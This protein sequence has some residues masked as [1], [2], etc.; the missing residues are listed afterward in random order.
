[1]RIAQIA[2]L[3][4]SVPPKTYGGAELVI[5]LLTEELV[6]RG[7]DVTL[8]AP[9]DS[10]TRARLH[11][12]QPVSVAEAMATRAA[13]EYGHYANA[14]MADALAVSG[15]FDL[16]HS[17]L[18]CAYAP[19]AV[20][21]AAPVLHTP[22]IALSLDDQWVLHHYPDTEI[23]AISQFQ[24]A[25]VPDCARGHCRVIHHGIDFSSY[26][27][28]ER[29][30]DYLLFLGRMG[31]QK[32]PLDAVRIAQ[33]AGLPLVLAGNPENDT[34]RAYFTREVLP[35]VDGERVT[36]VGAV[37]PAAK[38]ILLRGAVALLFPIRADEA[39]GLAMVEAMASGTPVLA[40][41]HSSTPEIVEEG[42]TG[43][44]GSTNEE[45]AARV[46][47]AMR[48]DRQRIRRQ[49]EQR[50]SHVRMTDDYLRVYAE[51]VEAAAT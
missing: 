2:P 24:A 11:S 13:Y 33:L 48:L 18:G 31:R 36:H 26:E 44:L 8:F 3:W 32:S 7:H 49:A 41:S 1:M 34:E 5:H 46:G 40:R 47:D 23:A 30:E 27:L 50:F 4:M 35:L 17:H 20:A 51:L 12:V 22:H 21:S 37:G 15:E 25:R 29:P 28:Q 45:I 19:F 42:V 39:F 43:F 14:I 6:R 38:R 16:I 10:Q 9:G